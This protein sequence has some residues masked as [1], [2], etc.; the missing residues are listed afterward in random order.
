MLLSPSICL[1]DIKLSL[2]SCVV[3]FWERAARSVI[4]MISVLC[5]FII[6]VALH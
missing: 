1:D 2:G 4:H 6:L 5:I 3:I